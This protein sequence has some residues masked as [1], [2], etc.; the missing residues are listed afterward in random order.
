MQNTLS[1][2]ERGKKLYLA[3]PINR[4]ADEK[5]MAE[6]VKI[7]SYLRKKALVKIFKNASLYNNTH[8]AMLFADKRGCLYGYAKL[9]GTTEDNLRDTI[10]PDVGIDENGGKTYDLGNQTVT[11]RMREDLSFLIELPDG[12]TAKSLPKKGADAEKYAADNTGFSSMKKNVK[13]IAKTRKDI[14][15]EEFLS[16]KSR[17]AQSWCDASIKHLVEPS[18]ITAQEQFGNQWIAYSSQRIDP[19]EFFEILDFSFRTYTRQVNHIVE[20]LDKRTIRDLIV[21]DDVSIVDRLASFTLAQIEEFL[22]L[23][24]DNSCMN[25]TAALLEFKNANFVGFDPMAECTLDF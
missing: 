17:S 25:V 8:A 20:L 11:A 4:Y 14:L 16:G 24:T 18:Y 19:Q 1:G 12:K 7:A 21:K 3:Y 23:A 13:K 6:L 2:V 22:K 10:L 15:F 9:R 5:R